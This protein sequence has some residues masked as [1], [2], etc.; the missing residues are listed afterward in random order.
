MSVRQAGHLEDHP[1]RR[2]ED[3]PARC[4]PDR[5]PR[6]RRLEGHRAECRPDRP[7]PAGCHPG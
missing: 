2:R 6:V 1:D 3:R 5:R 7:H 4:H